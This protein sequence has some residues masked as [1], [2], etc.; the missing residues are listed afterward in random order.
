MKKN[1]DSQKKKILVGKRPA[2]RNNNNAMIWQKKGNTLNECN[3]TSLTNDRT[4][5]YDIVKRLL[6]LHFVLGIG[7]AV[8]EYGTNGT[9]LRAFKLLIVMLSF[10]LLIILNRGSLRT[11]QRY[12]RHR[13]KDIIKSSLRRMYTI[14]TLFFQLICEMIVFSKNLGNNNE[15]PLR[16][17][18]C[19]VT[20]IL[21]YI[22]CIKI[23]K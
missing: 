3:I 15:I 18:M 11:D 19:I 10:G 21:L 20:I 13:K 5:L 6:L 1:L 23:K 2:N 12:N 14:Y 16:T 9:S 22:M 4:R 8:Y 7:S 17:I